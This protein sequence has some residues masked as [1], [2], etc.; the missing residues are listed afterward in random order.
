MHGLGI[1]IPKSWLSTYVAP[2]PA[3]APTPVATVAPVTRE[4]F[5][6]HYD[7]SRIFKNI[8]VVTDLRQQG[9]E[10]GEIQAGDNGTL[11]PG[12]IDPSQITSVKVVKP[13]NNLIPIAIAIGLFILLGG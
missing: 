10:R 3:P 6:P 13:Q 9:T 4:T 11:G 5:I 12:S 8:K 1:T 2:T 7:P